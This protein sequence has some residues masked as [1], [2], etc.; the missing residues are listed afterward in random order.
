MILPSDL[1]SGTADQDQ[2][3]DSVAEFH[4]GNKNS[5]FDNHNTDPN[6]STSQIQNRSTNRGSSEVLLSLP[7]VCPLGDLRPK[8]GTDWA[9]ARRVEKILR[10]KKKGMAS[11]PKKV[12]KSCKS[13]NYGEH[14]IYTI[15]GIFLGVATQHFLEPS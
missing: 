11:N 2:N 5:C 10:G 4:I 14:T 3:L 15:G 13:G 12:P 7:R 9:S 1:Q 6:I 8:T